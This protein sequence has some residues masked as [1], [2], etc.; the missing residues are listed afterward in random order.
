MVNL[1]PTVSSVRSID[2]SALVWPS[3]REASEGLRCDNHSY[4]DFRGFSWNDARRILAFEE[5]LVNRIKAAEDPEAA[6]N[7][8]MDE[9]YEDDEGL[10][11]MD[12]GVASAVVAL[13]AGECIPFTSC[14][15]GY[16]GDHHLEH[17]PLVGC[18]VRPDKISSLMNAAIEADV[19]M[20]NDENGAVFVY[21]SEIS[22][23]V[24]FA[25]S[26]I[27]QQ[28]RGVNTLI[29]HSENRKKFHR[30]N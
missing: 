21:T 22:G 15:G 13:S 17:Y 6:R 1:K 8:I 19:S 30:A 23:I 26:M 28:R 16:Y 3:E 10:F 25:R 7:E 18:Y 20:T 14:N 11:G 29:T 4:I 2:P 24:A 5:E 9:L 12:I 27:K